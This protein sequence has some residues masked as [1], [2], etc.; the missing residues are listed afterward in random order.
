MA[1]LSRYGSLHA[2][3]RVWRRQGRVHSDLWRPPKTFPPIRGGMDLSTDHLYRNALWCSWRD[4]KTMA[5]IMFNPSTAHVSS[6]P[7]GH[8][9]PDDTI[10]KI[11]GYTDRHRGG[12]FG[13]LHV[14]NLFSWRDPCRRC[15]L[16]QE[17]PVGESDDAIRRAIGESDAVVIAWGGLREWSRRLNGK[18]LAREEEVLEMLGDRP[19]L[20]LTKVDSGRFP[21][22]P[23]RKS[24]RLTLHPWD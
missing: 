9:A 6:F 19:R 23:Q 3:T 7:A 21:G 18:A 13:S 11:V 2:S 16:M 4:G 22:H 17:N 14:V 8:I 12:A 24:N 20:H 5:W 1:V 15:T 10:A